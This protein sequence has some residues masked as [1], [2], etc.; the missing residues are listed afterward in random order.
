MTE[1]IR[2]YVDIPDLP[3]YICVKDF[4][5]HYRNTILEADIKKFCT[6]CDRFQEAEPCNIGS[7][8][9]ARYAA[10]KLCGW[11]I[12]DGQHTVKRG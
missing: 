12:I 1:K 2:E 9:Q 7:N 3:P 8:D 10:R 5:K 4:P 6:G 11:V